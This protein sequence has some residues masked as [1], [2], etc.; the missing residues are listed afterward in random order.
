MDW[1][2]SEEFLLGVA[3]NDLR[4]DGSVQP[5]LTAFAGEQPLL[6]GWLR[7]HPPGGYVQPVVELLA[8]AGPLGADR[9]HLSVSGRAWSLDDPIPPVSGDADLRQRAVVLMRADGH[10]R[11]EARMASA[12]H[13]FD[14]DGDVVTWHDRV[15]PGPPEGPLPDLFRTSVIVMRDLHAPIDQLR[16]QARRCVLLGHTLALAPIVETQ[17]GLDA[18]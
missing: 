8:L 3:E 5:C 7:P 6:V 10:G 14:L 13:P 1:E 11:T 15:D 17:L 9:L 18:A 12:I 2:S 4:R 16:D